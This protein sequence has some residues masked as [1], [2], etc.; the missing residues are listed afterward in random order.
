MSI[1]DELERC[2][3]WIE[4]ALEYS[5]GTHSFEDVVRGINSSDY[6]FWP[7]ENG[8]LITEVIG[9]PRAKKVHV[10]LAGGELDQF[11]KME[12]SLMEWAKLVGASSVTLAGRVGWVKLLK[13]YKFKHLHSVLERKI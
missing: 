1:S 9:Y 12:E 11:K 2:K 6:Q 7:A 8:C 5:G 13:P 4:S 10:F 3:P